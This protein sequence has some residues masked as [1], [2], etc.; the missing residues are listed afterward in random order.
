[1]KRF[2]KAILGLLAFMPFVI[3]LVM[4]LIIYKK[5][6]GVNWLIQFPM[7][8]L[9]AVIGIGLVSRKKVVQIVGMVSLSVL[10]VFLGIMGYYDY[11]PWFSTIVGLILFVYFYMLKVVIRK[12][13]KM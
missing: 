6:G 9:L 11:I 5:I 12:T 1:M 13:N 7:L 8:V 3:C 4:P 10:T 2:N